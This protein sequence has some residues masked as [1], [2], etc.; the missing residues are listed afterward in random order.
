MRNDI[1]VRSIMHRE[2][3]GVSESD[4]LRDAAALLCEEEADA[5]IVLRGRQPVGMLS[6]RDAL[7]A[8]LSMDAS[9]A[10]VS[11]AMSDAGPTVEA[12]ESLSA[13][14]LQLAAGDGRMVVLDSGEPVGV[15]T[16]RDVLAATTSSP[17]EREN[18]TNPELEAD[19]AVGDEGAVDSAD[20]TRSICE[21]CGSLSYELVTRNGQLVCP[22]CEAV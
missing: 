17:E 13:A 15:I 1:T 9:E 10:T 19:L 6:A 14:E 18:E 21:V 16:D 20:M 7:S 5:A 11:D 2:F 12:D 8:F 22:D 3:V 4:S